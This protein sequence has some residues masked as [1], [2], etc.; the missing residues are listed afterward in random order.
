MQPDIAKGTIYKVLNSLIGNRI[1]K[2]IT[3]EADKI[4]YDGKV[5]HHHHLYFV[6]YDLIED[7][8]DEYLNQNLKNHFMK[9]KVKGFHHK[10]FVIKI[11]G[12]F[13]KC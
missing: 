1:I 5:E 7:Y 6:L 8:I 13:D 2:K 4:R 3:T 11:N 10:D 9:K 12:T